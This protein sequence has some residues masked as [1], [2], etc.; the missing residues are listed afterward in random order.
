MFI[1]TGKSLH[2]GFLAME[3]SLMQQLEIFWVSMVLPKKVLI[4]VNKNACALSTYL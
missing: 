4:K 2:T 1:L 3:N